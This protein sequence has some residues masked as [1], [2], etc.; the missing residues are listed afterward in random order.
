ML[1]ETSL[2]EAISIDK[3]ASWAMEQRDEAVEIATGRRASDGRARLYIFTGDLLALT[4]EGHGERA[5]TVLLT[6]AQAEALRDAL[7][8]LIS[9]MGERAGAERGAEKWSGVERRAYGELR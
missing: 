1:R 7:A 4:I 2:S 9:R 8:R 5:P 3:G 6:S